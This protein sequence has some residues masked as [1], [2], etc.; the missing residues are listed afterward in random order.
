MSNGGRGNWGYLDKTRKMAIP[1]QYESAGEF[2]D[3][4]APVRVKGKWGFIDQ[5]GKMVIPPQ[6]ASPRLAEGH[7]Q[8][9]DG[10][11]WVETYSKWGYIDKAGNMVIPPQFDGADGFS[12]GLARVQIGVEADA[13]YGFIDRS[14]AMVITPLSFG[15][16]EVY[17][18]KEG[19]A[20]VGLQGGYGFMDKTG[21]LVI[22]AAFKCAEDFAEGLAAVFLEREGKSSLLTRLGKS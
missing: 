8:F 13:T 11:A 18:F 5:T 3:G 9:Q 14:G 19:L 21:N 4:L 2:H 17:R 7:S 12:D 1:P 15:E 22:S 16:R 20:R 6:F 10:L